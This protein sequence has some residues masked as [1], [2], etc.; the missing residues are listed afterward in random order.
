MSRWWLR[1]KDRVFTRAELSG[2]A[3]APGMIA[4]SMLG[5]TAHWRRKRRGMDLITK[6]MI[7][8]GLA[9]VRPGCSVG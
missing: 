1:L 7:V 5:S 2:V 3:A 9:A 8:F 6:D 4:G